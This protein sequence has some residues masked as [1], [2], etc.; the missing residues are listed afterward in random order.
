MVRRA[1]F[2]L[3]DLDRGPVLSEPGL[4]NEG[5][6]FLPRLIACSGLELRRAQHGL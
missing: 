1:H 6:E 2:A 3:L 5:L 4:A